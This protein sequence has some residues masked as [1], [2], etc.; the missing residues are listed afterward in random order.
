MNNSLPVRPRVFL[1]GQENQNWALDEDLRLLQLALADSVAFTS[2]PA[3][4]VVHASWWQAIRQ[5]SWQHLV[6]KRI[7]CNL[8]ATPLR[9]LSLPEF[10]LAPQVVGAWIARTSE[11]QQQLA[12]VGLSSTLIP[13]IID[14]D[15][16]KPL[17]P[18]EPQLV[19]LRQT[20]HIPTDR[21][22]IGSFQRDT[23]GRDLSS[24][25]LVKGPDIFLEI[26]HALAARGH[27]IHVLLAGP[28]RFWLRRQLAAHGI[29]FTFVGTPDDRTD[30]MPANILP[31][32]TLNLLYNLLDLYMVTSRAEGGPHAILEAAATRCKIISTRVGLAT[33]VLEP[34]ALFALPDAIEL[35]EHD[36]T[37]NALAPTVDPHYQRVMQH[38]RVATVAPR[39]R[40]FYQ[41]LDQVPS[42][43]GFTSRQAAATS[44]LQKPPIWIRALRRIGIQPAAKPAS[45][46]LLH[47]FMP[48]PWGGGNQFML[49]LQHA[50]EKRG[51]HLVQN[52][53]ADT[54]QGY[55]INSVQF[56]QKLL[57]RLARVR[58]PRVVHR[59]DGPIA[60]IRGTDDALDQ[61][62]FA[63]NQQFASATVIQSNWTYQRLV[64][65]GFRP[66]RPVIIHNAVDPD[67][68][69]RR[70]RLPF[71]PERKI[72]LI[73][74]SWSDNPRKGGA[75]YRWIEEHLDCN[76]FEYTFV[77]R[78]AEPFKHI[79]HIPPLPSA[80]LA[81][82]LR[83]HDIYITAS[84]NDPCSNALIEALTCGLPA[85]YIN[86]GGHPE[87]VGSGGL[88]FNHEDEILPQ[89]ER[90]VEHYTLFQNLIVVPDM[91]EVAGKYL[92][93]LQDEGA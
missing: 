91:D 77:G 3:C 75:V 18:D 2:L 41:Q 14:T 42:F 22:L 78:V 64:E 8:Q 4:D 32:S 46:A 34:T 82:V 86:D 65:M 67:I 21:Y 83:Q 48:P 38:Y 19:A 36:I 81:D 27:P 13:Y 40:E 5:L 47:K 45:I 58:N 29:P 93:L 23:E 90:L 57:G 88:P 30:D 71:S 53:V 31:R 63:I 39:L 49:A 26:V 24:P 9:L 35:V 50:L 54:I 85:L 25:K 6:G 10:R 61:Q 92:A 11:A 69:H 37:T 16:F 1:T 74:T 55:V 89:L 87:L 76:R 43:P 70:G 73:S 60:L 72:R 51:H 80:E 68:F 59:I 62:C 56:D 28:R 12:S 52:T 7:V 20:W 15:T 17:P 44:G 79:H 66:I 33:D 84:Q